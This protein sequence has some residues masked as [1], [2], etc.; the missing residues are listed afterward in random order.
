MYFCIQILNE[1]LD[2]S[3][4]MHNQQAD[5]T[6]KAD[7]EISLK[8]LLSK[9]RETVKYIYK[10]KILV[11]L[12]GCIFGL[13]GLLYSYIE[14]AKY[15]AV[16]TFVLDDAIGTGGIGQYAGL[17][18]MVGLDVN[19]SG[20]LFQGEN[21]FEL[22][23]SRTMIINTLLKKVTIG[24]HSE[25]LVDRYIAINHLREKWAKDPKLKNIQFGEKVIPGSERLRDSVL[26]TIVDNIRIKY[27]N[28]AKVDKKLIIIRVSVTA[29]D[30]FFAKT[31]NDQ[32]VLTVNDFYIQTKTKRSLQTV[33]ILQHQADS[34]RRTLNGAVY[35]S[36]AITDATPNLNPS[37]GTLRTGVQISQFNAEASKAILTEIIKNL[38]LSKISLRKETPLI[39]LIDS[40]M[41]PL[42]KE[43]T[44]K[45]KSLIVGGIIGG[46][47]T[48]LALVMTRVFKFL[49]N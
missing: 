44:G 35:H 1:I 13:L 39:Q 41:Y 6:Y 48:I 18:S 12:V 7:E 30:E 10:K 31:F 28:V 34:V 3:Q 5:V 9:L 49:L 19:S 40:P 37:R 25:L 46:I 8:D 36:A 42:E 29:P 11:L 16:C 23:K 27:L 38:E 33:N 43:K 21:I 22:Y 32:I 47:F 14:E 17:A 2:I 26:Q 20:G 24:Q 15:T 4:F 45:L